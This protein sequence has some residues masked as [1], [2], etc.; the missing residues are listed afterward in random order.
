MLWDKS[1]NRIAK[2]FAVMV[3]VVAEQT[4]KY[5]AGAILQSVG[6]DLLCLKNPLLSI[7]MVS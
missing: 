2:L 7:F 6:S 5:V 1:A 3:T 4:R